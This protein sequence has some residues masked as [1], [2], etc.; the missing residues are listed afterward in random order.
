MTTGSPAPFIS[1]TPPKPLQ[2]VEMPM[3]PRIEAPV[4]LLKTW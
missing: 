1:Q 3:G 4:V 2:I